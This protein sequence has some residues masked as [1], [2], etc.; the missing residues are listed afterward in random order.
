M[1]PVLL[2]L[3]PVRLAA[4]AVGFLI[5]N[6]TFPVTQ[7]ADIAV[8]EVQANR[9]PPVVCTD[10]MDWFPIRV[11]GQE[12]GPLVYTFRVRNN[13]DGERRVIVA[14]KEYRSATKTKKGS[15][16]A[17]RVLPSQ[18]TS[19]IALDLHPP[20]EP[21]KWDAVTEIYV[22]ARLGISKRELVK[23]MT[24][25]FDV[26][27]PGRFPFHPRQPNTVGDACPTYARYE[28]KTEG[29]SGK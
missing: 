14:V 15:D 25:P 8:Q 11:A 19:D 9:R 21:G 24:L 17:E 18:G 10:Y 28:V 3:N 13:S 7:A 12:I 20:R 5:A 2:L 16:S 26:A 27:E 22:S 29:S 4:V 6:T 1:K 23:E